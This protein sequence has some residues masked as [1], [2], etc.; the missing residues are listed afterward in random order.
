MTPTH[1]LV[2]IDKLGNHASFNP[3]ADSANPRMIFNLTDAIKVDLSEANIKAV[4]IAIGK[5]LKEDGFNDTYQQGSISG[6]V[7]GIKAIIKPIK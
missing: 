2:P 3:I 6:T 1:V 4:A 5:S 7:L